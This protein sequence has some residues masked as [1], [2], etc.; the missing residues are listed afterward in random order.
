MS[1]VDLLTAALS[2][3][4]LFVLFVVLR[5]TRSCSGHCDGC[6]GSCPTKGGNL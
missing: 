4:A 2:T 1:F 6:T 5:P 3:A